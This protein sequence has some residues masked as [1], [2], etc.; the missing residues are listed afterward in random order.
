MRDILYRVGVI[1]LIA[2]MAIGCT[3]EF[4]PETSEEDQLLVVEGFIESG[5][6]AMP[7]FVILTKSVP[8][9]ST[10]TARLDW[11]TCCPSQ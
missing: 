6:N 11:M 10:I 1:G 4:V 9:I 7:T 5:E 3:Q 8:F 2:L